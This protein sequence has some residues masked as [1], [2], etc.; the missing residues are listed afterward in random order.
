MSEACEGDEGLFAEV[1]GVMANAS[2]MPTE[3]AA[4]GSAPDPFAALGQIGPYRIVEQI[5]EGAFGLVYR[6]EREQP[7]RR[8]VALK[9][10]KPGMDSRA[11]LARFHAE[12]QALALMNHPN[13]AQVLEGGATEDGRPYFVMEFVRG[14]PI[15]DHCRRHQLSLEDRVRLFIDVCHALQ[16]AHQKGVIHRD[17][18]PSNILVHYVDGHATPKVIDFG[19]AKALNQPLTEQT[20]FTAR[21]DLIGTP[22]YMSPEQAE[23]TAQDIDTRSDIYSLGVVLYEIMTGSVP[24]NRGL[25]ASKGYSEFCRIVREEEPLRPSTRITRVDAEGASQ[26][27]TSG[28]AQE[29]RRRLRGDLDWIVLRCLEKDR[30]RRYGTAAAL[31][32]DLARFLDGHAVSASPPST[33]Y[34][35]SKFVR[36]NRALVTASGLTAVA[37]VVATALSASFWVREM[38]MRGLA[39]AESTRATKAEADGRRELQRALDA[40]ARAAKALSEAEDAREVAQE[41]ERYL[42]SDLF[43]QAGPRAARGRDITVSD[44]MQFAIDG[45]AE[46][47]N[48]HVE[49]A[50]RVAIGGV[51]SQLGEYQRASE[52]FDL[53]LGIQTALYGDLD[54]RVADTLN[55]YGLLCRSSSAPDDAYERGTEMIKRAVDIRITLLGEDH[56]LTQRTLLDAEW[57]AARATQDW[58]GASIFSPLVLGIVR[59]ICEIE[60]TPEEMLDAIRESVADADEMWRL[61]QK[62]AAILAVR[63]FFERCRTRDDPN[64]AER[65]ALAVLGAGLELIGRTPYSGAGEAVLIYATRFASEH[66]P[67]DH[68]TTIH[69][70]SRLATSRAFL[71]RYEEAAPDLMRLLPIAERVNSETHQ[72]T[73]VILQGLATC[74]AALDEPGSGSTIRRAAPRANGQRRRL[75]RR[76]PQ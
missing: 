9:L 2:K 45:L 6:A 12:R 53:G 59:T 38:T 17:V 66:F 4:V 3:A 62:E 70:Q 50:V 22:E 41:V 60:E 69:V 27:P 47:E 18:K 28:D 15:T 11:V 46:I 21:G 64:V 10:I 13:V 75:A 58:G 32:D 54:L 5:G 63:R 26:A 20:V 68:P 44:A 48:S 61:G 14:L 65:Y 1:Q 39:E 67:P 35:M 31:A 29:W 40:E 72:E 30:D 71:H 49:A 23:S 25:L 33:A 56:V 8:T 24:F 52:Q 37:L 43:A 74:H 34:R 19:V 7:Y 73:I 51:L 76:D 57:S 16:H 42:I 36:R 55:E